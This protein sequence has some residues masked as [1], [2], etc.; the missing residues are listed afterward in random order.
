MAYNFIRE[1]FTNKNSNIESGTSKEECNQSNKVVDDTGKSV[2]IEP[3]E[4]FRLLVYNVFIVGLTFNSFLSMI[5]MLINPVN[6][7]SVN[8]LFY[9]IGIFIYSAVLIDALYSL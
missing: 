1:Y 5:G 9:I 3:T 8:G 4:N 7:I 2:Y 6:I